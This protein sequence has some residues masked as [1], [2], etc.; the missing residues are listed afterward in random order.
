MTYRTLIVE[1][2]ADI[3]ESV[4]DTLESLGHEHDW[5]KS[6]EEARQMIAATQNESNRY[7]Y[8]LLDL[9][10]PV[11]FGRGLASIEHG[12]H[13][14]KEMH[15]NPTMHGLPIIVMTAY[16][17][18]GLEIATNLC[19]HGVVAFINK[20]FPHTG[21]TL[22]SVIQ[23]VLTQTYRKHNSINNE[24]SLKPENLFQGGD[25]VFYPD[26]AELC[27][28]SILTPSKSAQ[29][30]TIL[31]ALTQRRDNDRYKSL[32]GNALAALVTGNG[33]QGSIAGS[34][35]DFRRNVAEILAQ[36]LG[37]KIEP[38]DVIE[39]SNAGYRFNA[40]ITIKNPPPPTEA[41][42]GNTRS[43]EESVSDDPSVQRQS[44][45]LTLLATGERLRGPGI[46]DKLRFSP[47]TAK[48]E[49]ESLKAQ[50]KIEFVGA[51]K[52]GYYKIVP[53]PQNEG[54]ND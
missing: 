45:I 20:P 54:T 49:V 28:V 38:D 51:A 10:I 44:Q 9:Q 15:Q 23:S 19:E 36:E 52:T 40:K 22:A 42:Q 14:A 2:D 6:Q 3:V 41:R 21:R 4:I 29:M 47:T 33:G 48:R 31:K 17:K 27:G 25:L 12:E 37:Q 34:I 53:S 7:T 18:E 50:G 39:T 5:A 43:M 26:R 16:G 1:D 32:A 8:V 30:W 13:L 24:K 11:K 35:R 46:A